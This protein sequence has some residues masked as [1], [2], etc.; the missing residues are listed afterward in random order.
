MFELIIGAIIIW[1][2]FK[3][4]DAW[5]IARHQKKNPLVTRHVIQDGNGT[6]WVVEETAELDPNPY[7]TIEELRKGRPDLRLVK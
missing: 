6:Y 1:G 2:V 4:L 5:S 3:I 7:D